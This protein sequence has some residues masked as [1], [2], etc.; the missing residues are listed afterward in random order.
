MYH[1]VVLCPAQ[2]RN[3]KFWHPADNSRWAC[4]LFSVDYAGAQ[5][6]CAVSPR[7]KSYKTGHRFALEKYFKA[8]RSGKGKG[9]HTWYSASLWIISKALRYGTCSQKISQFYLHTDTFNP[10]SE[11]AISA[12]AFLTIAGTHLPTQEGWKTELAWVA[13]YVVRQFTCP[14]AVTHPIT[15]R[16]QCSAT[17]LIGTNAWGIGPRRFPALQGLHGRQFH[18]ASSSG[19]L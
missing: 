9:T 8:A 18:W 16:A 4:D 17:A 2:W 6:I 10:Q 13:G 19:S 3:L 14:K 1:F 15:N 7:V 11:W 12:V 5:R